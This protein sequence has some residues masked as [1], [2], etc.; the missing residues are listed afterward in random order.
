MPDRE[1]SKQAKQ[2]LEIERAFGITEIPIASAVSNQTVPVSSA[3]SPADGGKSKRLAELKKEFQNCAL[4]VLSQ[5][6]TQVVF[7]SGNPEAKLMF[8][9]EAPGFDEDQQ[10]LPF[11]G[12]AGQLLTKIIEAMKL[13][14]EKVYIANCLKCRP[15]NNRNPLPTEIVTC[16]P[17]LMR[18]IEIIKPQIIC[19]LGKFATQTLLRTEESI[20]RLRGRFFDGSA[21]LTTNPELNRGID[22]TQIKIMPTF[23]PAYLLRNPADKKLVWADVQAIMKE[24]AAR[25]E[26]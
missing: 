16:Q 23:H 11:V 20:S 5:T 26:R 10:G 17:I 7:G 9:G 1:L 12:A 25:N 3:Q 22:W 19:T 18:Q 4:C 21:L 24:L 15:P 6:R 14:R 8:V 2:F 13:T